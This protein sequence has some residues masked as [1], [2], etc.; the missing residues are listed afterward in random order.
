MKFVA[1]LSGG[2]DSIYNLLEAVTRGHELVCIANL[3]PSEA[4]E[5]DSS[6]YQNIGVEIVPYIAKCLNAPLVRRQ[7]AGTA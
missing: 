5:T 2:K 6:M 7:I 1:L 3:H 4:K